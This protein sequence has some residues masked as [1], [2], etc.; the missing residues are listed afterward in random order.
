M[1]FLN[2][3]WH[4]KYNSSLCSSF[5]KFLKH[6]THLWTENMKIPIQVNTTKRNSIYTRQRTTRVKIQ[7]IH[8]L[9]PTEIQLG[10][11]IWTTV[12]FCRVSGAEI[13]TLWC[14][15]PCASISRWH[16]NCAIQPQDSFIWSQHLLK[17]S[18]L[19]ISTSD[20]WLDIAQS[21][22]SCLKICICTPRWQPYNRLPFLFSFLS[23]ICSVQN[24]FLKHSH[25]MFWETLYLHCN[26]QVSVLSSRYLRKVFIPYEYHF[27][28]QLK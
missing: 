18:K 2:Q 28:A 21:Q 6:I 19:L 10:T 4:W 8:V 23:A 27:N 1:K 7:A 11:I 9:C 12:W 14:F 25:K 24:S 20:W 26:F 5:P 13:F 22:T 17:L 16:K 15:L 3:M